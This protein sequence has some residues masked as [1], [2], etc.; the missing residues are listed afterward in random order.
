MKLGQHNGIVRRD[1]GWSCLSCG[2]AWGFEESPP[3]FC[4]EAKRSATTPIRVTDREKAL[5]KAS[6]ESEGESVSGWI[7]KAVIEK[8]N[9]E[10]R[11]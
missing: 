6:A 7:R 8:L 2:S 11:A 1:A 5:I 9:S 4:H 10:A 3:R